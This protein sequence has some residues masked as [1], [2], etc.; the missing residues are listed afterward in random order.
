[1]SAHSFHLGYRPDLD[2]F[3][4]LAILAVLGIHVHPSLLLGGFIGVDLFFVLSGFL[5]TALLLQEGNRNGT[6]RL[7][8]FYL[9][10]ALRLFPALGVFL[11]VCW[12]LTWW[13]FPKAEVRVFRHD[14]VGVLGYYYNWTRAWPGRTPAYSLSHL[15]SLSVEEQFYLVWPLVLAVLLRRRL[16]QSMIVG[17]VLV[18]IATSAG[19]RIAWCRGLDSIPRLYFGT[20]THADGLLIGCLVGLL[21]SWDRLPTNQVA[22]VCLRLASLG[23]VGILGWHAVCG[24]HLINV[25]MY[26][27]GLLLVALA[28]GV[29]L[30]ALLQS[31][32]RMLRLILEFPILVWLGRISY[33]LYL[34]HFPVCLHLP[35]FLTG[36]S[37]AQQIL[38]QCGVSLLLAVLSFYGIERPFLR[39]KERLQRRSIETAPFQTVTRPKL[40]A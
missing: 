24:R 18:G 14:V 21:A 12:L 28:S 9:R 5:I 27:W 25:Y 17:I 2:G 33:G 15:W 30:V 34:W 37:V 7:A 16:P 40:A 38:I 35:F 6:I 23:A 10:R 26:R 39:L 29:L 20:D 13:F 19:L 31:A 36:F 11:L 3:R 8:D 1:M 22:L 4:G 32:P